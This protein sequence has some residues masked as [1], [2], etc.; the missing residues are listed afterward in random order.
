MKN[1][2]TND[3]NVLIDIRHVAK[4]AGLEL[5]SSETKKYSMQLPKILRYF[6]QLSKVDTEDVM[7]LVHAIGLKNV[8]R[9]DKTIPSFTS[10]EALSNAQE[11]HNDFFKI[12]AIFDAEP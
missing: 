6:K 9:E 11:I 2:K 7:P 4:L 3:T 10:Q 5:A 12:K 1:K 8:W